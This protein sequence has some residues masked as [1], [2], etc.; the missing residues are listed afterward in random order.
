MKS[1]ITKSDSS[2]PVAETAAYLFDDWFDRTEAEVRDRVRGFVQAL[3]E[4]ELDATLRRPRYRRRPKS[5]RA[6]IGE[7][8]CRRLGGRT[9]TTMHLWR[10]RA[11]AC[12]M[13]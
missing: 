1:F 5:R 11:S 6:R 7:G 10:M 4:G 8:V 9:G 13:R 2:Q 12:M 3:I